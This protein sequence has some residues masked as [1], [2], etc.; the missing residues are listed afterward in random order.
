MP[1]FFPDRLDDAL[2][3]GYAQ[4]TE[5]G[6]QEAGVRCLWLGSPHRLSLAAR[7][8]LA[9]NAAKERRSLSGCRW[10]LGLSMRD[11]LLTE[12]GGILGPPIPEMYPHECEFRVC[13]LPADV[14][15][16]L[17]SQALLLGPHDEELE[18][19]SL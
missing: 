19:I 6:K 13:D 7:F 2:A 11:R 12:S 1:S 9:V 15:P 8:E 14:M 3:L 10:K 18:R 17:G 16:L 4:L 5:L